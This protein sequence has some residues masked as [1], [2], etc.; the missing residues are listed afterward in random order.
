MKKDWLL[1]SGLL[2]RCVQI[3]DSPGNEWWTLESS[4]MNLITKKIPTNDN[5][6]NSEGLKTLV[7]AHLRAPRHQQAPAR[8]L[9]LLHTWQELR[10]LW[11]K[12]IEMKLTSLEAGIGR[13]REAGDR[14]AK[15][16]DEATKQRKELEVNIY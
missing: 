3:A 14:V 4:L 10:E 6:I 15:L 5:T 1:N 7:D 12:E 2:H 13:L 8:F 9:A 16:E 11:T